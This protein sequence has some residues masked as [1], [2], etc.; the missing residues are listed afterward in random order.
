MTKGRKG[1]SGAL[2]IISNKDDC[3][4]K[5]LQNL[6]V[7]YGFIPLGLNFVFC[8]SADYIF[9]LTVGTFLSHLVI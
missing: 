7:V 8:P 6:I 1:G 9:S 3:T 2:E 4:N 5:F